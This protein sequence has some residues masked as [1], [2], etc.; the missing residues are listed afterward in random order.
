MTTKAAILKAIRRKCLDCS[1]YQPKEVELCP[2]TRCELHP[3][4]FGKD[5]TPAKRGFAKN[6]SSTRANF[7]GAGPSDEEAPPDAH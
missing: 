5:P 1:C 4:R 2:C 6:P 3:Y 7:D